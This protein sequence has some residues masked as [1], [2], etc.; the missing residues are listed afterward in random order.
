VICG[1]FERTWAER[2]QAKAP[3]DRA[4]ITKRRRVSTRTTY[5][6]RCCLRTERAPVRR[7]DLATQ[8]R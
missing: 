3:V 2:L 5:R 6:N 4:P 8:N 7:R 1:D